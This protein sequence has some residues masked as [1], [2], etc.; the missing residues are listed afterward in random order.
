MLTFK[1]LC[2]KRMLTVK[3]E[4][5]NSRLETS[6]TFRERM[7]FSLHC[8]KVTLA[9]WRVLEWDSSVH[10]GNN[11]IAQLDPGGILYSRLGSDLIYSVG[12]SLDSSTCCF[13]ECVGLMIPLNDTKLLSCKKTISADCYFHD[14]LGVTEYK[15][16]EVEMSNYG[17]AP[18]TVYALN[19]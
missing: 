1:V 4:E 17:L 5:R 11:E 2:K 18:Y 19:I 14:F 12:F 6:F 15:N 9:L 16:P 3:L 13:F 7:T 10:W 8:V